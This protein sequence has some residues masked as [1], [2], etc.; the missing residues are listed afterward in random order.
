MRIGIIGSGK[1]GASAALRFVEAGHEVAIANTR[2]PASLAELVEGLG[3]RA[4]AATVED[5]AAFGEVVLVAIP[6][7]RYHELPSAPL[8]GKI[9]VDATNYYPGRDGHVPELDDDTNTSSQLLAA[10]LPDARVLKAFNTIYWEVLRDAPQPESGDGR[11]VVVVAGDDTQAKDRL[12]QLI[13]E[14]GFTALD[15]GDLAEGG[16]RQQ[17]GAPIYRV[18]PS[19]RPE[20]EELLART[21]SRA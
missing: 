20:A 3:E 18:E 6:F 15:N 14:I 17:P 16:R 8:A 7:G 13:E 4:R 5:A 2:G 1:I 21:P 12:S 10:H 19:T 9:V 11:F